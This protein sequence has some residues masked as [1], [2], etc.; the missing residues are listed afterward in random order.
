[1]ATQLILVEM[2]DKNIKPNIVTYGCLINL[3]AKTLRSDKV[4]DILNKMR[5]ENVPPNVIIYG[6]A[7][8]CFAKTG[9][10]K[11][12][13]HIIQDM[14]KNEIEPDNHIYTNLAKAYTKAGEYE[15]AIQL[16]EEVKET[17]GDLIFY[18]VIINSCGKGGSGKKSVEYLREMEKIGL[19]PTTL[20][21]NQVLESLVRSN[22]LELAFDI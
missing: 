19:T 9:D 3:Y 15:K 14:K 1:M 12:C 5:K 18:N 13:D 10:I 6:S 8:S 22:E 7:L 20:T 11:S 21:Y 4:L 16:F 2:E 17:H